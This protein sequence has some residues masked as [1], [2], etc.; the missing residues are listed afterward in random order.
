MNRAQLADAMLKGKQTE[1]VRESQTAYV[2]YWQ[3]R[4]ICLACALGLAVIGYFDG[5]YQEAER[6]F[7]VGIQKNYGLPA[8]ALFAVILDISTDLAVEVEFRHLNGTSIE[9]IA[10]W[11][12]SSE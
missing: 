12:K 11:L 7:R 8:Q 5:D 6:V 1:G 2:T 4:G 9:D 10:A 3:K